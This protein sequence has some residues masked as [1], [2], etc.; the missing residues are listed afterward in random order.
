MEQYDWYV[1]ID[2]SAA[3]IAQTFLAMYKAGRGELWL[4][5]AKALCDSITRVQRADGMIPT[6]WMNDDFRNGKNLW[7]SCM[8]QTARIMLEMSESLEQNG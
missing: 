8:F 6:H 2:N 4:E 3:D 1:P 7:I 5:K